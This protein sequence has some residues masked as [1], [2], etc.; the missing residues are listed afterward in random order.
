MF[1]IKEKLLEV[2]K[3]ARRINEQQKTGIRFF[4]YLLFILISHLVHSSHFSIKTQAG[5]HLTSSEKAWTTKIRAFKFSTYFEFEHYWQNA[6]LLPYISISPSF[7]PLQSAYRKFYSTE[8]ALL[9]LTNFFFLNLFQDC[10]QPF[11]HEMLS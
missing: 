6:R 1:F 9:K 2:K 10:I 8:T 5:T 11:G 4:I 3:N 7:C